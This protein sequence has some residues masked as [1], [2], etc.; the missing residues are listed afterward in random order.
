MNTELHLVQPAWLAA[1]LAARPRPADDG[2]RLDEVLA[3]AGENVARATGGPFAAAV[4]DEATGERLACAVNTVV[5]NRCALAHAETVALGLA[6]QAA[7]HWSLAGRACV[8][9]A[10]A[11]PCAM[12]VGAIGWSGVRR[13]LY[14]ATRADVEAIGFDE[15]ARPARWKQALAARGIRVDG[16]RGRRRGQAVLAAYGAAGGVVYNGGGA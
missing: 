5:A 4:Y 11:E 13:V 1:F 12:C 9:V 2:A 15:G 3:L 14:A 10:S 8:L 16:P 6:Q 7:G